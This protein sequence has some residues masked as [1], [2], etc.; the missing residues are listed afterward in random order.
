MS[1]RDIRKG[2]D[3]DLI[4]G[5]GINLTTV[6]VQI[7]GLP[8]GAD[9]RIVRGN[10]DDGKFSVCH[11]AGSRLLCVEAVNSP[12]D[13][14]GA[15]ALIGQKPA[16]DLDKVADSAIALKAAILSG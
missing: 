4:R 15:K 3:V 9:R 13:F 1:E 7:A 11:L 12:A 2:F 14:L 10:P 6:R 5:I 16:M 8:L